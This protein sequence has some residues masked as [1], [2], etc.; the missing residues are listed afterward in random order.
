MY[1]MIKTLGE[2]KNQDAKY[3]ICLLVFSIITRFLALG[4]PIIGVD[5]GFYLFTGGQL[6]HGA[7][8]FVDIWDR[9]PLGLFILYAFFHLFGPYRVWAFEIG[10][11]ISVWLTGVVLMRMARTIAPA[12]G[13]FV[14]AL[15]YIAWTVLEGGDGG[16]SP[17]FYNLPVAMA[18]ALVLR[19]PVHKSSTPQDIARTARKVMLLF[20]IAI[21]IKYTVIF[22]GA[23]AGLFLIY[24]LYKAGASYRDIFV[25]MLAWMAIALAPTT[26][27]A[28]AY[29]AM[30]H[31][32]DWW[33]ANILSIFHRTGLSSARQEGIRMLWLTAPLLLSFPLRPFLSAPM[34][35]QQ[36]RC[37]QFLNL[38]ALAAVGGVC[39][40]GTR[41][42]HYALPMLPPLAVAAAPL[43]NRKA[44]KIWLCLV[45]IYATVKGQVLLAK[46]LHTQG[47][48]QRFRAVIA[49]V[50]NPEGCVFVYGGSPIVYDFTKYCHLTTHPFPDHLN[51]TVEEHATGINQQDEI[52]KIL[53]SRPTYILTHEP[54]D[55]AEN[56]L[57][58]QMV[59]QEIRANYQET[60]RTVQGQKNWVVY[61]RIH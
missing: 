24:C 29:V 43:W 10:A 49:A 46:H 31:G 37:A 35:D 53:A 5:V 4:N 55:I 54:G 52:R 57:I 15:L 17:V 1:K 20:G 23:F 25:Q 11:L 14:A 32:Y 27:I 34:D 19:G 3:I 22:E 51:S 45:V 13:A 38:W 6:L 61:K 60:F 56:E 40:M 48:A 12:S 42:L 44:G 59:Y 2:E 9:K 36:K 41:Y 8:P 21:Q 28:L 26:V 39:I 47:N 33:Y 50:S 58:R 16:Q 18:M 7:I 30:G